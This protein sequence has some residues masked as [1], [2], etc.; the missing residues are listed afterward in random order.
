MTFVLSG[1]ED[2]FSSSAW[3]LS[4]VAVAIFFV[5][6]FTVLFCKR[7]HYWKTAFPKVPKPKNPFNGQP[8][9]NPELM[10]C[11]MQSI[12]SENE[13]ILVAELVK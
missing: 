1:N 3:I 11:K 2:I 13:Q 12:T 5:A 7:T 9:I 10:E 4:V 6:F 8:D